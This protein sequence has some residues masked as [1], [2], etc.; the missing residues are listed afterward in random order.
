V[1]EGI[2]EVEVKKEI[3]KVGVKV[4]VLKQWSEGRNIRRVG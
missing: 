1:K 2:L 4:E 3:L